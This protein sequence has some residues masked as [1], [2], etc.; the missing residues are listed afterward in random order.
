MTGPGSSPSTE[1]LAHLDG[2][3]YFA[4][5][6]R[7]NAGTVVAHYAT[8]TPDSPQLR[9]DCDV[10][11]R[12]RGGLSHHGEREVPGYDDEP[13]AAHQLMACLEAINAIEEEAPD[14]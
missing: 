6:W 2:C 9:D 4:W 8:R 5:V 11:D 12:V 14:A 10:C 13:T 1:P 7:N 3:H